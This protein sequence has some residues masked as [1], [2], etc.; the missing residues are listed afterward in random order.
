MSNENDRA[1]LGNALKENLSISAKMTPD[2]LAYQVLAVLH[3]AGFAV[4]RVV[5][6]S[7]R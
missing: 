6:I 7:G 3:N 5:K 1:V 2:E 4:V